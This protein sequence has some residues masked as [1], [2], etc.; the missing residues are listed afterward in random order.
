MSPDP[1]KRPLQTQRDNGPVVWARGLVL[2][3]LLAGCGVSIHDMAANGDVERV[4]AML[5][6]A[7]GLLESTNRE[8]KAKGK[9]PLH[10][11]VTYGR[12]EVVAFLIGKGANVN[13]DDET[14]MTPLHIAATLDRVAEAEALVEYGADLE[15]RDA[16]GD[17]PLHMAAIHDKRRILRWLVEAGAD[18]H[19]ENNAGL[20]PIQSA[21]RHRRENAVTVLEQWDVVND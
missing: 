16:F 7:P 8:G 12:E 13:A 11:A 15:A 18:V 9:T 20:T 5:E 3:M 6:Q 4:A 2:A 17:T 19:A 10:Y 1:L 21:R 14:G